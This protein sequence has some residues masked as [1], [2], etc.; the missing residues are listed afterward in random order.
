M[1]P[2]NP[3]AAAELPAITQE[4]M[5]EVDRAMIED[6]GIELKMMMENAGRALAILAVERFLGSD[7]RSKR[8][9]VLA[10]PGGNGGGALVCARRLHN[11]GADVVVATSASEDR[12]KPVPDQQLRIVQRMGLPVMVARS[13][14]KTGRVDLIIDGIIGY[15]LMGPPRGAAAELIRWA[16]AARAPVLS[17]D[18]PSGLDT[19]TGASYETVVC[20]DATMTLALPKTGLQSGPARDLTGEL[21][22]ADISVPPELYRDTLDLT[23]GPLFSPA[24]SG[25]AK[26]IIRVPPP[27]S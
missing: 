11:W 27:S 23:V 14:T 15:S 13:P 6:Y 22:V 5:V 25:P 1:T 3:L 8:V 12:F 9:I 18:T 10:G 16:N 19:T 21:F 26:D 17:L 20:A 24:T 7:P 4:Q 2:T